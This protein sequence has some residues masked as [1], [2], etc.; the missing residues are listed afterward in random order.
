MKGTKKKVMFK[1]LLATVLALI[2]VLTYV[3]V[4]NNT[5]SYAKSTTKTSTTVEK[6]SVSSKAK[7]A[8]EGQK[9]NETS[10]RK[11]ATVKVKKKGKIYTVKAYTVS[12][13]TYVK[14]NGTGKNK[15]KFVVKVT[16]GGKSTYLTYGL[17]KITQIYVKSSDVSMLE[18]GSTFNSN[19]FKQKTTVYAKYKVGKTYKEYKLHTYTVSAAKTVSANS[20]KHKGYYEVTL[21]YG[22]KST[23]RYI[24]VI[25]GIKATSSF[26]FLNENEKLNATTFKNSITAKRIFATGKTW[27]IPTKNFKLVNCPSVVKANSKAHPGYI[28]VK[29]Q[30]G[31]KATYAYVKV[32]SL[33]GITVTSNT[34]TTLTEGTTFNERDFR[35]KIVVSTSNTV[36]STNKVITD[37][38]VTVPSN[39]I[40]PDSNGNFIVTIT[41]NG[42]QTNVAVPVVAKPIVL[43]KIE[44]S[45]SDDFSLNEGD[46]FDKAA[47]SNNVTVYAVYSD[48]N[49]ETITDYTVDIPNSTVSPDS[50]GNFIVTITYNGK[51]TS[52]AIPVI[53]KPI[54][55]ENIKATLINDYSLNEEDAFDEAAFRNN[56]TVNAIY[57]NNSSEKITDYTVTVPSNTVSPDSNGNFIVTITYNGKQTSVA[58]PVIAKPIILEKIEA[59]LADGFS[60]NERDI[61]DEAT[62]RNNITVYAVYSDGNKETITD[63]TVKTSTYKVYPDSNGIFEITI[64][65]NEKK[66]TIPVTVIPDTPTHNFVDWVGYNKISGKEYIDDPDESGIICIYAAMNVP[67]EYQEKYEVA[68]WGVIFSKTDPD[69]TWDSPGYYNT[70]D[71]SSYSQSYLFG[72]PYDDEDHQ[73]KNGDLIYFRSYVALK[74][75]SDTSNAPKKYYFYSNQVLPITIRDYR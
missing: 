7:Y 42:K 65:Y 37:Y 23:V 17:R 69:P 1:R 18:K 50:N 9:F 41:Y 33:T 10:F 44:A 48:G 39:T 12:A 67:E 59:S 57:S 11:N 74:K 15:G 31:N 25:T 32:N 19:S 68:H 24:N 46:T 75:K 51:Q 5:T 35:S 22:S 36:S 64:T 66:T 40:S 45:L 30:S 34:N 2:M 72:F 61:F 71:E 60:L 28:G 54:V 6:I 63:Y 43:E 3:V 27:T 53:A 21:K 8:Y 47:F 62:F 20:K 38:T 16:Y 26:E 70:T 55:L 4:D 58:V 13:P 49:K 56:V 29:V 73:F 14:A 52:V